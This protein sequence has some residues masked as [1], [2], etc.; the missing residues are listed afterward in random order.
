MDFNRNVRQISRMK[1]KINRITKPFDRS[2]IERQEFAEAILRELPRDGSVEVKP[3]LTLFRVSAPTEPVYGV[4][5]SCFC[6][7]A[8]GAKH[9]MLGQEP[10]PVRPQSLFDQHSGIA[11]HKPNRRGFAKATLPWI[12]PGPRSRCGDF[13]H[14]GIGV[15][16]ATERQRQGHCG[17]QTRCRLAERLPAP[18]AA[19]PVARAISGAGTASHSRDHLPASHRRAG[20]SHAPPGNDWRPRPSHGSGC[21]KLAREFRQAPS[22]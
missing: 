19:A 4:S 18:T 20:P 3:G 5:D 13:D 17:Q 11:N 7:I 10:P 22:Y 2:E 14:G 8:Q 6:V 12:A 21:P 16:S 1:S 9:V 15:R